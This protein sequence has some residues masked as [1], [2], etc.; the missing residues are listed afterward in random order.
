MKDIL[1]LINKY[2]IK[3]NTIE[4]LTYLIF[5]VIFLYLFAQ[6]FIVFDL[7]YKENVI[8]NYWI[9]QTLKYVWIALVLWLI[10]KFEKRLI[11]SLQA[12]KEIDKSCSFDDDRITNA[13]EMITDPPEGNKLIIETYLTETSRQIYSL[14]P[15]LNKKLFN[16]SLFYISIII[17]SLLFQLIITNGQIINSFTNFL[18]HKKPIEIFQQTIELT[19]G[20]INVSS[21]TSVNVR[22]LNRFEQ[23]NYFIFYKFEE[24]WRSESLIEGNRQFNNIDRSFDYYITNQWASSDTFKINVLDDPN[25]K[26][27]SLK[28]TYPSYINRRTELINNS[29]GII[30]VPQFTEIEMIIETPES[31]NEANIVFSDRSFIKMDNYGRDSWIVTFTPTE[32]INYHFSL[33]DQLGNTNQIIHRSINII[34]DQTP[35]IDFI[36]P[37]KDTLMTQ[38]NLF[39]TRLAASDDYGLRNLRIFYQINQNPVR[40]TL[41][42]RQSSLNFVTL[43]YVFDFRKTP[44][45]PVDEVTYWAEIFDNSPLNQ[46]AETRRFKLRFPSIEDIFR[47]L[48]REDDERSNTLNQALEEM[49]EMQREFDMQR[50]EMLRRDEF[51]WEDQQALERFINEQQNL[52]EMVQ[53]VAENYDRMIEH[54]QQN[55]AV[56]QEI[57]DK[58]QRIQE[59]MESITTEDLRKAMEQL[60]NSLENM[61]PDE[62]RNAMENFQFNMQDFAEKLEQT[63]KLLENIKNEQNIE[64]N[65]EIMKEMASMQEELLNRTEQASD[66]TSLTDEQQRLQ[67]KLDALK[68]QM[69][70]T[71]DDMSNSSN[72]DLLQQMQDMLSELN[73]SQLS[74]DLSDATQALSENQKQEAMSSQQQALSQMKKMVSEMEQMQSSMSGAGMQMMTE[75]IQMTMY[76]MMMISKEHQNKV[77]RIGNDIIPYMPGFVNDFESV[78]IAINQLYQEPQVLLFL[79]QKFFNDLNDLINAYRSLFTDIQNSRFTTHQRHTRDIQAGINLT[80][81]NLMQV[82]NNMQQGGGGGEGGMQ[83]LMQSLEQMSA[84]Q[85]M[86]NTMTHSIMEQMSQSGN[87]MT[88]QMRQQMQDMAAEEERLAN[89]LRRMMHT[90]PE[91]QRHSNALNEI[92][93]ELDEVSQRIRQN[94]IDSQLVEQQNNIMSRLLEVQRSINSRDRSSQ[95]RGETAEERIWEIPPNLDIDFNNLTD[96]RL[97][98]D[99]LQ[100]LP[101]DYR[102]MILE[103]LRR[104]N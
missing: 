3:Q 81:H 77:L 32:S 1:K 15:L 28:Y 20:N 88:N 19:P 66:V 16:K 37:A 6:I 31:V 64:R 71:I 93:K 53:N 97:L 99:E 82:L 58:M 57:L 69:Q 76:R 21:G 103:Y 41:L 48:Q 40:D 22:V 13:Y 50:R 25:V 39:E 17:I 73:D 52:N 98:E 90:N 63:L 35:L 87:R 104:M 96:R 75:A 26:R 95:R 101:A 84:Q 74:D 67:D 91:A 24:T 79:G 70:K 60:Q 33:I 94:R 46:K 2:K 7:F 10:I 27:I 68:E 51:T 72:Q 12:A 92:V 59:I 11:N 45:F 102:Q 34:K 78:Q 5:S 18:R 56:S 14:K 23:A 36:Y 83:S 85:M 9:S 55:E 4:I 80:I 65:L 54:L 100:R 29:D 43:A 38:N 30:S 8:A 42:F 44:L 86:M 47:E 89:N 62:V 61:N 49:Q